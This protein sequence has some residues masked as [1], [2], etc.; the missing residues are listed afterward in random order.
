MI[1]IIHPD[2]IPVSTAV[3]RSAAHESTLKMR[4]GTH[5]AQPVMQHYGIE[6]TIRASLAM[7]NTVDELD[8][9]VRAI[10]KVKTMFD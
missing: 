9:L 2:V 5:C 4:T 10:Q 3:L 7:Y 1:F 8:S 6:G